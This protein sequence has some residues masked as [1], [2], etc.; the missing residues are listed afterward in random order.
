MSATQVNDSSFDLRSDVDMDTLFNRFIS[1][2][3][4]VIKSKSSQLINLTQLIH[5]KENG[6]EVTIE[7]EPIVKRLYIASRLEGDTCSVLAKTEKDPK[8]ARELLDMAQDKYKQ[9]LSQKTD[10]EMAF[11]N[12]GTVLMMMGKQHVMNGEWFLADKKMNE[13]YTKFGKA[14]EIKNDYWKV[15]NTWA[16]CLAHHSNVFVMTAHNTPDLDQR[17]NQLKIGMTYLEMARS[18]IEQGLK[19][20]PKKK[21]MQL[22]KVL[23]ESQIA[24]IMMLMGDVQRAHQHLIGELSLVNDLISSQPTTQMA[25]AKA[26]VLFNL[27][28][29][30][31]QLNE[32]VDGHHFL[33]EAREIWK[34][35]QDEASALYNLAC[36]DGL[37]GNIEGCKEWLMKGLK[38]GKLPPNEHMKHDGDLKCVRDL[39]WFQQLLNADAV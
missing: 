8:K 3:G 7:N 32:N 28:K 31:S 29:T 1:L 6:D 11:L 12:W 20:N 18:K 39:D 17:T 2:S 38:N 5:H 36:C 19:H 34:A 30:S 21:S 4:L 33:D 9:V 22:S 16:T 26:Y 23:V 10:D 35:N 15:M 27:H 13:A 24:D 25:C 14:M 37:D